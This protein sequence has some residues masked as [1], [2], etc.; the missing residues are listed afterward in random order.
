MQAMG[1]V[2]ILTDRFDRALLYATHVHGGDPA[3]TEVRFRALYTGL[4]DRMLRAW[5]NPLSDLVFEGGGARSDEAMPETT[6]VSVEENRDQARRPS[7]SP[8]RPAPPRYA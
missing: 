3:K 6:T 4:S 5:A 2:T 1:L 7:A 8:R